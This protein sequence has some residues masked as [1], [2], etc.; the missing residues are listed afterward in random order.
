M[1]MRPELNGSKYFGENIAFD[2][3]DETVVD[4]DTIVVGDLKFEVLHTPGHSLGSMCLKS[5]DKL[6]SGDTLFP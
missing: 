5:E 6:F 2:Q 3:A 1:M 4:K